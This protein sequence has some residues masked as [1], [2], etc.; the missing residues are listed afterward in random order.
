SY[1]LVTNSERA[2]DACAPQRA[3]HVV[4]IDAAGNVGIL[5]GGLVEDVAAGHHE[6]PIPRQPESGADIPHLARREP[7]DAGVVRRLR[8]G[9]RAD[10]IAVGPGAV[11]L[12]VEPAVA[13]TN[14][15]VARLFRHADAKAFENDPRERTVKAEALEDAGQEGQLLAV[16]EGNALRL[17]RA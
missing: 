3:V 16:F 10:P 17:E 14:A 9:Q 1:I 7:A 4:E 8:I 15:P 11:E 2:A 5:D 13:I 12:G 6:L